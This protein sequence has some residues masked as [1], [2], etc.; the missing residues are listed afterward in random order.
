[1]AR[2][3]WVLGLLL[4]LV[5]TVVA[6]TWLAR[7]TPGTAAGDT[8]FDIASQ[9]YLEALQS[10]FTSIA[11]RVKP[12]VV[13]IVVE[14][15]VERAEVQE[16]DVRIYGDPRW[17]D[18]LPPELRDFFYPGPDDD[19]GR[20]DPWRLD[21]RRQRQRTPRIP[22]GQGSGVIIDT[23]G[24]VLT[25]NHVVG[26]AAKVTVYVAGG[27]SYSA[28]VVG[29]DKLTDL[30]VIKIEPKGELH[31]AKLGDADE[32]KVGSWV[33]AV[34]YPFGGTRFGGRFDPAQR[35]EPT[36][37]VGVISATHRQ[38]PSD[39]VGRPF[40]DLIQTDAS[41]NLGNSGGPLVN[42]KAEVIGINQAIFSS[43][44][45]PGNIG[46][47]FAIPVNAGTK[48]IIE[49]L[50]GGEPV[51]RGQLGVLV[52]PLTS[53]LQEVYGADHGVFVE[54]VMPDTPASRGGLKAE[55]VIT[56]YDGGKVTSVDQF[57]TLVQTT[58]PGTTVELE[59]VRDGKP[60]TVEVT[61]EALSFEVATAKP[62]EAKA[63]RLGLTVEDLSQEEAEE[64]E[65]SAGV[66]ITSVDPLGDGARA[67][68]GPGDII[69]KINRQPVTD[70]KS[71][72]D[73]LAD[74]EKGDPIAI[75]VWRQGRL[76][77]AQIDQL[78]Q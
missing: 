34:G 12:S 51:V 10:G 38:I 26:N 66:R 9:S 17:R 2:I 11:D 49:S 37:T 52:A 27:D 78:S 74:L 59:V 45:S 73:V 22:M 6:V 19:E 58:K 16:D 71:Y 54:E 61:V 35:W 47:G 77:T 64:A 39:N 32:G 70:V 46:V 40:R 4:V 44:M 14:Q 8:E 65:L 31:A 76:S 67:G 72:R 48:E 57:V 24:Y 56:D 18:M 62:K 20:A 60:K 21:P 53:T 68:I 30:A 36:V 75:R 1:M 25:N 63:D 42:V 5:S 55:D 3:A 69:V 28:E 7:P 13:F 29:T 33:M 15:K 50:K 43:P 23:S 41:I